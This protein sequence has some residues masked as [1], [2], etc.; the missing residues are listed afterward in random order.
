MS[1][2]IAAIRD[3]FAALY[4]SHAAGDPVEVAGT[5]E[6]LGT[7]FVVDDDTIF[8]AVDQD[9]VEREL[10]WYLNQS[11][12]VDDIPGKVPKIWKDIAA[13]DG[14]I[15]SNYGYLFMSEGNGSQLAHVVDHIKREPE[16]RRAVAVY[17]NPDVHTLWNHDGRR[18]MICTTAVCYYPRGGQ[19]HAV[20]SMRS[21]DSVFG[22]RN[23]LAWQRYAL[24]MVCEQTGLEPGEI[25]WQAGSL[26]IYRR[27][28]WMI[29]HYIET[30]EFDPPLKRAKA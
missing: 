5:L 17:T 15:L 28:Y 23:D 22:F 2:N 7:S 12:Y 18:D 29:E 3:Q 9:Y 8:G 4:Q 20:V 26:H 25:V 11:L 24:G 30:G 10:E 14:T 27:H 1:G 13:N 19:V 16:G 6:L 21:G